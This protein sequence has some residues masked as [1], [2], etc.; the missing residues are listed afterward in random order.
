V[1]YGNTGKPV[2]LWRWQADRQYAQGNTP[3]VVELRADGAARP[4]EPHAAESQNTTGAGVW[5]DG[6]WTVVIRRPLQTEAGTAE[7]QLS[8]GDLIPV[9]FHVW[10]GNN[11]E[12]GLRMSLSS[13][14][15]IDLHVPAPVTSYLAVL[16]LV[17]VAGALEWV[18]IQWVRRGSAQGRLERFGLPAAEPSREMS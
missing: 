7:V 1:V 4:P 10:E 15:F 6:R 5:A 8:P 2:D 17:L 14:T 12:T 18:L 9:A 11:G 13:W 3:A 16:L